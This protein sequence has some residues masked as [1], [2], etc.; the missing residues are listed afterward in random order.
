MLDSNKV[1]KRM[2][3]ILNVTPERVVDEAILQELV[4]DSFILIDMVIDLQNTFNLRLNQ[5]DLVHVK[6]VGDLIS[7]MKSKI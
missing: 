3:E 1:K 4:I 2:S 5:E 6:T 7:I